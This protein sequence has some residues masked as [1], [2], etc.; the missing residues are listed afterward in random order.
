[1]AKQEE[2]KK[3]HRLQVQKLV[4]YIIALCVTAIG[5]SVIQTTGQK[6]ELTH[7]PLGIA[8]VLWTISIFLGLRY[9]SSS[10]SI[11]YNN[12]L[13]FDILKGN[14]ADFN[15]NEAT[16]KYAANIA[17]EKTQEIAEKYEYHLIAQEILFY[18]GVLSFLIWHIIKMYNY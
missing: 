12:N 13:Y 1:M 9:L 11:L 6:L 3:E 10:I 2:I 14:I 18:F 4:Y 16:Q 5:F 17:M 7:L 8:V 15:K